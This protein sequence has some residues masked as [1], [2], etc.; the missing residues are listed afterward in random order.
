MP[1][2]TDPDGPPGRPVKPHKVFD[3]SRVRRTAHEASLTKQGPARRG[4][5]RRM[6]ATGTPQAV[7][8]IPFEKA[9]TRIAAAGPA[10]LNV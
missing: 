3:H 6:K 10:R 8:N 4:P 9:T 7:P 5:V 1:I 2:S